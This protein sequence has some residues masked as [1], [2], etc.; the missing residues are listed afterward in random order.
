MAPTRLLH[1]EQYI[2]LSELSTETFDSAA[3][4]VVG[5]H[6]FMGSR[7]VSG[8]LNEWNVKREG[9]HIVL[10][11]H[12][13]Y[14]TAREKA[15]DQPVLDI[16]DAID[17]HRLLRDRI[18]DEVYTQNNEVQYFERLTEDVNGQT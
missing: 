4:A 14:L 7:I 10:D 17:P 2:R 13:R 11:F 15:A 12:N 18:K 8:G 1:S 9:G 5:I 6:Q 3:A 16:P